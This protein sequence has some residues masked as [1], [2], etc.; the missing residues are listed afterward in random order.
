VLATFFGSANLGPSKPLGGILLGLACF[1]AEIGLLAS[2]PM[3][4]RTRPGGSPSQ[5]QDDPFLPWPKVWSVL[6]GAVSG[7]VMALVP[8]SDGERE[9]Y[10]SAG[11]VQPAQPCWTSGF[12][13]PIAY[14]FPWDNLAPRGFSWGA[15]ATDWALLGPEHLA[16]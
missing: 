15:F 1:L 10:C 8:F 3:Y 7:L 11:R 13:Y 2:S 5:V 4:Q 9:T 16:G 6:A 14:R 12:G